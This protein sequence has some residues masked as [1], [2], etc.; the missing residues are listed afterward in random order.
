MA[1]TCASCGAVS[2]SGEG[3]QS[4]AVARRKDW[5]PLCYPKAVARIAFWHLMAAPVGMGIAWAL[6]RIP[7]Q[8]TLAWFMLNLFLTL[9]FQSL[10]VL[11]HELG[12]ALAARALGVKVFR[13]VSGIGPRLLDVPMLG[14][15]LEINAFQSSGFT[16]MGDP[17]ESGLRLRL[18]LSTAAGPAVNA[19]LLAAVVPW[20]N[21]PNPFKGWL[22]GWAPLSAF[23]LA[24]VLILIFNLIP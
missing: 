13:I 8:A 24:N 18:W 11:P 17:R 1:K 6:T 19:L 21:R 2:E 15:T 12:H 7:S 4:T 16:A 22:S 10:A 9:L 3:Y 14:G 23:A 5:C 20:L